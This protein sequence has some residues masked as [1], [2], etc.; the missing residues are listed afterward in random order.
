MLRAVA[1]NPRRFRAC[2]PLTISRG[3]RRLLILIATTS[4]FLSRVSGEYISVHGRRCA[5]RAYSTSVFIRQSYFARS[6]IVARRLYS[7]ERTT[8]GVSPL[9]TSRR[10]GKNRRLSRA[11]RGG[12]KEAIVRVARAIVYSVRV[13][14]SLSPS[15][16][17]CPK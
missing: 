9:G 5:R 7:R 11:I 6:P 1:E 8:A 4:V 15:L 13:S 14:L 3:R 12:H 16:R 10:P 2:F 17:R